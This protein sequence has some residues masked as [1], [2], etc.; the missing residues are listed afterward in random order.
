MKTILLTTLIIGLSFNTYAADYKCDDEDSKTSAAFPANETKDSN[1]S[2]SEPLRHCEALSRGHIAK[3]YNNGSRSSN[4][5]WEPY[6]NRSCCKKVKDKKQIDQAEFG[7]CM[8]AA[9]KE[10]SS[11]EAIAFLINAYDRDWNNQ[12]HISSDNVSGGGNGAAAMANNKNASAA[13]VMA[14]ASSIK[15]KSM[16]IE[17]LD[18]DACKKFQVQLDLIEGVQQ[19]GYATQ[20]LVYQDKI[21]DSQT[22][23]TNEQNAATGALKAQGESYSMQKDMYN[24]RTAVDATKLAYLYSIY[25]E[26]PTYEDMQS[27]CGTFSSVKPQGLK[28]PMTKEICTAA[29][30]TGGGGFATTMNQS[31]RD[32]MKSKLIAIA[33]SAGSNAILANLM[34]KRADDINKAIAKIDAYKPIDPFTVSEDEAMTTFCKQNPGLPQCL[35]GGLERTFDTMGENVI[36]FGDGGTGTSYGSLNN[37]T[38]NNANGESGDSSTRNSVAPVGG[39]IAAANKDNSIEDSSAAKVTQGGTG[40]SGGGGGGV[41]G[42]GAGGGGGGGTPQAPQQGGVA[43]AVQG[44]TPTY[45]GGDGSIS[46]MGGFGINKKKGDE[47]EGDN[48]FS[49]MFGK[50]APKGT[51]VVNFRDI[52]SKVGGKGD[53][54]FDM[55]SK[56]YSAV[57]S[58]KRLI[59]YELTK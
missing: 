28:Q 23:Y 1:Y 31:Q 46:L 47:K 57:S 54:L 32:A 52:A 24:Q 20:Q 15:C 43:A 26:M 11:C 12:E 42:G 29:A 39:I 10:A 36:T 56:R 53:N 22:K 40:S 41:G 49:K 48:P 5:D 27:K 35:T 50:D 44:K 51:G 18:Y 21:L 9:E 34:G 17:T 37:S 38:D 3:L 30:K 4:F 59:E 8:K 58:D 13:T 19:V 33:T 55:I 25:N 16:G 14:G 2:G 45:G 7:K 6:L